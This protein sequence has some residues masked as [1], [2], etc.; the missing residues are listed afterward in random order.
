M[1]P[2]SI[3]RGALLLVVGRGAAAVISFVTPFILVRLLTQTE[4]GVYKQL[5]LIYATL[6]QILPLGV[7]ASLYYFIPLDRERRTAY[8]LHVELLLAAAGLVATI[9]LYYA[10]DAVAAL[11]GT[12]VLSEHLLEVALFTGFMMVSAALE[13]LLVIDGKEGKAAGA[14]VLSELGKSIALLCPLLL[15]RDLH[16]MMWSMVGISVVRVI[17]LIIYVIRT[18]GNGIIELSL[19]EI[20]RQY[21]YAIPFGLAT[22]VT[23]FQGSV[24]K[25]V[26]S[27]W[28]GPAAFAIYSVGC[29][30]LSI[31]FVLQHSLAEVALVKMTKM[32]SVGQFDDLVNV[33]R[34]CTVNLAMVFVP[35]CAFLFIIREEFI[36][37]VFT[38]IYLDSIPI[39]GVTVFLVPLNAL[40][41]DTILRVFGDTRAILYITV[42]SGLLTLGTL[43]PL[44]EWFGLVGAA[45]S[46]VMAVVLHRVLLLWRSAGIV[47]RTM[48][49]LFPWKEY[50]SI[51]ILAA[52]SAIMSETLIKF[53]PISPTL[54]IAGAAGVFVPT[55]LLLAFNTNLLDQ[56]YREELTLRMRQMLRWVTPTA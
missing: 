20:Y 3:L 38:K 31:L 2:P 13:M 48:A 47:Q 18:W 53:A 50:G 6:Y 9:V 14:T 37:V 44:L 34:Q 22:C 15:W 23:V 25:Y 45:A 32:K 10:R 56:E 33:W 1:N 46:W 12:P 49:T 54:R 28:L 16:V 27:A 8:I 11:L 55:Y 36:E 43:Y 26:V 21:A 52:I 39:F 29:F 19:A 5:F 17:A 51:V 40:L 24:D 35:I 42:A 7:L 30:Q 41:S 4:F